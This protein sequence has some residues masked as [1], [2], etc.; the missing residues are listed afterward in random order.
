MYANQEIH[1]QESLELARELRRR[2]EEDEKN[3]L[4]T[5]SPA[6]GIRAKYLLLPVP[7]LE[8][9]KVRAKITKREKF[10]M[11]KRMVQGSIM[12]AIGVCGLTATAK[13]ASD[14]AQ[15]LLS[16]R[17]QWTASA[18]LIGPLDRGGEHF[19]S[20]KD[21]SFVKVKNRWQVFCTLRG[22]NRH[23]QIEYLTFS[24]WN[25][26][27]RGERHL[28]EITDGYYCAPQVF[29]FAPHK[30]WY[31]LYQYA[32]GAKEDVNRVPVFS[33]NADIADWRAWSKPIPL[34]KEAGQ[35]V[36]NWI[37]FWVICDRRNAFLFFTCDDGTMWRASTTLNDF[38]SGWSKPK[39]AL[40][41][42]IFEASHTYALRGT[43]K[44]LT[45]IEAIGGER[46]Y[47]KSF[48]AN[49][50]GGE[51]KPAGAMWE[52]PFAGRVN[53]AQPAGRWTD[54]VSHGELFRAGNDQRMEV[55]PKNLRMLFQGV[56]DAEMRG[57][58]YGEIPWRLGILS[59]SDS[60]LTRGRCAA[61]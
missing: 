3:R 45:I 54:S 46:R 21:P 48:V 24:D 6:Y 40:K 35:L 49:A 30:R 36:P 43:G 52:Q 12:A 44:Y 25:H 26:V 42:D 28:L 19:Y 51:W 9:A 32:N 53:V 1:P 55:D 58:G 31:L 5:P 47:Y 14:A 37:D 10:S 29:Y 60:R 4:R 38:P 18:P 50:L 39:L 22:K 20:I 34:Y 59:P 15:N 41:G 23:Q 33:T 8:G 11:K 16:G 27:E 17:H 61:Y 13:P 56:S 7:S 2:E 57:K